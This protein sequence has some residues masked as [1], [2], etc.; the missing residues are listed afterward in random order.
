MHP[1][2]KQVAKSFTDLV[3]PP[4]CLHCYNS[5]DP[6]HA[7]FCTHCL[8]LLIP[9]DPKERCPYCFTADFNGQIEKCCLTC[10]ERSPLIDRMAA[11][12]DYEG[13][14]AT[15]IKQ[16]KYGGQTYLA[17]GAGAYLTAQFLELGW[18]LPDLIIPMPMAPLRRIERGYNQSLFLAEV[19]AS[20]LSCPVADILRRS[21]GDFSQAGLN[22][23]QRLQ[24]RSEA[25][26]VKK[27]VAVY[28]KCL[29][30]I[31]DVM[32]TGSSLSCCAEVLRALCPQ[33]IYTLTVCRAI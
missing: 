16:L 21:G 8:K 28:D 23:Q 17:K 9:I 27:G 26:S 25:F 24:L 18:P 33:H 10:R 7:L 5:L 13:P 3:Y 1:I 22:H 2:F 12:F 11:V 6:G 31:D 32:T 30:I 4:I 15:L 29:L 14:A 20:L 19:M